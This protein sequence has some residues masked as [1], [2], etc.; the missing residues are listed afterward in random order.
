MIYTYSLTHP[1]KK[2]SAKIKNYTSLHSNL[3][4]AVKNK[5]A[6]NESSYN[7]ILTHIQSLVKNTIALKSS[8]FFTSELRAIAKIKPL[9]QP[10]A[11]GGVA[12]KKVDVAKDIIQK[13]LIIKKSGVLGFEIHKKKKEH[14]Q[15]R[16]GYCVIFF[17]H[18]AKKNHT[19][20][21]VQCAGPGDTFTFQPK[22]EH[23]MLTITNCVIEETSTNHLDDLVYIFNAHL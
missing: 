3:Q 7:E 11:W 18:H 17:I 22:D 13:L 6:T 16:E 21:S 23:G 8:S 14:L 20:I 9:T 12:L 4:E 10:T 19:V 1:S 5:S 15:I 2:T